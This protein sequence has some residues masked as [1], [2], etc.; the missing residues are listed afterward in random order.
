MTNQSSIGGR[1]P[2]Y[3]LGLNSR[4]VS[5]PTCSNGRPT[6]AKAFSAYFRLRNRGVAKESITP[7]RH[8]G[9]SRIQ[10]P[11]LFSGV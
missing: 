1:I 8:P 2:D 7:L 6:Y 5:L 4:G 11:L 9:D 10:H 3:R